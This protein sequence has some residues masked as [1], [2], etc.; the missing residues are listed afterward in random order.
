VAEQ[1]PT[2][3]TGHYDL[4]PAAKFMLAVL[5]EDDAQTEAL[6]DAHGDHVLLGG[7][8]SMFLCFGSLAF[9]GDPRPFHQWL[10][11]TALGL[12]LDPL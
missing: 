10:T 6:R 1:I 12:D 3:D 8:A 4:L 7:V 11:E 2:N 5:A 9:N